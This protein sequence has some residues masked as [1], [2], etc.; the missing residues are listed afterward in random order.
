MKIITSLLVAALSLPATAGLIRHDTPDTSYTQFATS[1][2]FSG[3]GLIFGDT[4]DSSYSCSGTVINKNWVLTAGHCVNKANAM[5]F[6][7]PSESGWR[8]YEAD[9][10]V[11]HESYSDANIFAGWDIGLM[12][13]DT[14][15]DV[16]PAQLYSGSSEWL[17]LS[18]S[19]GFGYT[20]NGETGIEFIDYQRRAGTNI[21]DD[22]WSA[23]GNG[24]QILWSDFDHPTD[25]SYNALDFL[26][27]D[28]DD[29]ATVLELMIAPG[30][31]GGGVFIQEDGQ[32]YLAGVH[33]FISD[34]SGD[35]AFG[36]GDVFGS[37]RVSSFVD[38][39]DGKVNAQSVPES[40]GGM[41]AL[42]GL[43]GL[44]ARRTRK[45]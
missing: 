1:P 43:M 34:F 7:L 31:S 37:T 20:G 38:W 45:A 33:S 39:I 44:V 19:A 28:F 35:G 3:V 13:F 15:F 8:F 21:I 42:I 26:G 22:L 36:Y 32:L 25:A 23:E 18:A 27:V 11:A 2:E 24:Q 30:D 29:L 4:A 5:S 41:L 16:A 17:Q 14:D 40:G 6:Y 9:S 12:H 10:W